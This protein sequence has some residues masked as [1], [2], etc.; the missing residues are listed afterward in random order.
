MITRE[1]ILNKTLYGAGIYSHI[2]RELYPNE[3]V[4]HISGRDCGTIRNPF[5]NGDLTLKID[6]VR[7]QPEKKLSDEL[8]VHHDLSGTIPD[9]DA[10]DF[11][12]R[13][14]GK[15]GHFLLEHLNNEMHLHLEEDY[16]PY[17]PK[18]DKPH[19]PRF[20]FFRAPI[21]NIHPYKSITFT[22]AYDYITGPYAASQTRALRSIK[23]HKQARLYKAAHFDYATFCGQFAIRSDKEIRQPSG[24]ICLDFDHIPDVESLFQALLKDEY[25]E[26]ELLF[27]SPSGRG[28]KWVIPIAENRLSHAEYFRT[29]ANYIRQTYSIE[30]DRSGKDLSRACFL[31]HDPD[32]FL[33][34]KY[35]RHA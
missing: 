35:A 26:T 5:H 19:G 17:G 30:V 7:L 23:D 8:A 20:S 27:R 1:T 24:L 25:F 14:Y 22:D 18:T 3:T 31:P 9:G 28:L 4:M 34:P 29:V 10:L 2:I 15:S 11:A 21:T 13:Y 12:E 32:A 33:N 6:I 16:N